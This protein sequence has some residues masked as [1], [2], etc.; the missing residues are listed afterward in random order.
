MFQSFLLYLCSFFF[1]VFFHFNG[2]VDSLIRLE[3]YH[4]A[5][6]YMSN[7]NTPFDLLIPGHM[8]FSNGAY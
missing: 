2:V 4:I 8:T 3:L 5:I 7:V 6:Y 1:N